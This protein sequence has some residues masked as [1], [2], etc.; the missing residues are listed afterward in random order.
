MGAVMASGAS[1][2]DEQ[3]TPENWMYPPA[4]GWTYDQVK[5]LVLPFDWEL[6]GGK[7]VVRGAAKWWH[8]TVR[9]ELYYRLRGDKP[10]GLMVNSEQSI[11]IDR[12]NAPKPDIVVFDRTGLDIATVDCI[13]AEK[14]V[15]A[16]EVV[17]PGSASEDRLYKPAV[18]SGAGIGSYWRVERDE[19]EAP[20]LYEFWKHRE[21]DCYIPRPDQAIHV[22]T[23][24][25]DQPFPVEIDLRS[26]IDF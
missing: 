21:V 14:V 25:T 8:N 13:P 20:V 17:S 15:L 7:I 22:G 19:D 4:D 16:V 3:A 2:Q 26:L 6:L 10:A 18:Y 12:K 9:D 11:L 1:R 23:L 5:E 24:K